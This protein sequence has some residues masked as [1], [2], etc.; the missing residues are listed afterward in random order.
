M[1][2]LMYYD[3]LTKLFAQ[4]QLFTTIT[5]DKPACGLKTIL[6]FKVPYQSLSRHRAQSV[7]GYIEILA[8]SR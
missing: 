6:S 1:N 2:S 3:H 7:Q 8:K 5:V 4:Y